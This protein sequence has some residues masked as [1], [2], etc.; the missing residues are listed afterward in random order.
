MADSEFV[1]VA[2][3]IWVIAG[4]SEAWTGVVAGV[5]GVG[6]MAVGVVVATNGGAIGSL[7]GGLAGGF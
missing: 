4:G 1:V 6:V 2:V 7:Q 3:S 5:V